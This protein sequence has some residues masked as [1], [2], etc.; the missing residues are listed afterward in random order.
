MKPNMKSYY[1]IT[2]TMLTLLSI[3]TTSPLNA[4]VSF[5]DG[6]NSLELGGAI[7]T[8]YNYR[9]YPSER[10]NR[11]KNNFTL[12]NAQLAIEGRIGRS[13]EFQVDY[14]FAKVGL[15]DAE[16]PALMDA[17]FTYKT[18]PVNFQVGYMKVPYSRSSLTPYQHMPFIQRSIVGKGDIYSRRDVGLMLTKTLINQQLNLYAGVFSGLGEGVVSNNFGGDNDPSGNPEFIAR[19]DF[20]F[21]SRLRYREFDL[22][23]VPVPQFAIGVNARTANKINNSSQALDY[24]LKYVDG[25]KTAGGFDLA[26]QY[27]GLTAQL[28]AHQIWVRPRNAATMIYTAEDPQTGQNVVRNWVGR[29]R[30]YLAA[31]YVAQISYHLR[32]AR[33]VFAIRYD[34]FNNNNLRPFDSSENLSIA[35]N[36]LVDGT[37]S[38]IKLQYFQR[39]VKDYVNGPTD[40][41]I[42]LG[43]QYVFK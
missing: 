17:N 33:S 26:F 27:Q 36:Y 31:G 28:E 2:L 9:F 34:G 21:P 11:D 23:H 3:G 38:V 8:Y 15:E 1:P 18:K 14:N 29:E 30:T 4:Q 43:W 42:R 32:P 37:R 7:F 41:Q 19:A 16:N 22:V 20:A 13:A 25:S 5:T 12:R 40:D 24:Q 6:R 39:I 10:V 35:Y